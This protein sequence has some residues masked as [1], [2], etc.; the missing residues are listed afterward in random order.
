MFTLRFLVGFNR[1][2]IDKLFI[3]YNFEVNFDFLFY[4]LTF[5]ILKRN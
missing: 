4:I 5:K 1:L 3:Y 2:L